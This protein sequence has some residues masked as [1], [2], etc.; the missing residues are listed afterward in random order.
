MKIIKLFLLI[1]FACVCLLAYSSGKDK[2][3]YKITD[4]LKF[5]KPKSIIKNNFAGSYIVNC[6]SGGIGCGITGS[7]YCPLGMKACPPPVPY[8]YVKTRCVDY[9]SSYS[10]A[11]DIGTPDPSCPGPTNCP[12]PEN[13]PTAHTWECIYGTVS[14]GCYPGWSPGNPHCAT[15]RPCDDVPPM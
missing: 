8:M 7:L 14:Y 13:P 12:T 2:V 9:T 15:L 11:I 10:C 4:V 3:N 6:M 1:P 5:D